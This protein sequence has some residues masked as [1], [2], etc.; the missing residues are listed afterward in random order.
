MGVQASEAELLKV[1]HNYVFLIYKTSML[2]ENAVY[3]IDIVMA[4]ENDG[5][6]D[7]LNEGY[8]AIA[9]PIK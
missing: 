6:T 8:R 7:K 4:D 2:P 3:D 5:P 1:N 9:I